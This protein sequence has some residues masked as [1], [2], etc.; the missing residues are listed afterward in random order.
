MV[1]HVYNVAEDG[2]V[3][4]VEVWRDE[5]GLDAFMERLQPVLGA[6]HRRPGERRVLETNDVVIEG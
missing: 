6:G 2:T 5:A 4:V 1:A 3:V